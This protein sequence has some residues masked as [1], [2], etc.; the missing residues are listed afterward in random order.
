VGGVDQTEAGEAET[1]IAFGV[2]DLSALATRLRA[3]AA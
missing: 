2:S 1:R 3:A